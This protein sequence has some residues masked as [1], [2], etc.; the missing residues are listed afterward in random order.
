MSYDPTF[1]LCPSQ[2]STASTLLETHD[3]LLTKIMLG[4]SFMRGFEYDD[5]RPTMGSTCESLQ[6]PSAMVA[7]NSLFVV[8]SQRHSPHLPSQ[9]S[10]AS[11]LLIPDN[12]DDAVYAL[13]QGDSFVPNIEQGQEEM[14]FPNTNPSSQFQHPSVD[15]QT[16]IH[17]ENFGN[18]LNTSTQESSPNS[19]V[20]FTEGR[21][22]VGFGDGLPPHNY[23]S[24]ARPVGRHLAHE[25]QPYPAIH[26]HLAMLPNFNDSQGQSHPG[27]TSSRAYDA[28]DV[29]HVAPARGA[30]YLCPPVGDSTN[31]YSRQMPMPIPIPRL[32]IH[33]PREL[34]PRA[35]Y[36]PSVPAPRYS[37]PFQAP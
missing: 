1:Q 21:L 12:W 33:S 28:D 23:A 2:V 37:P 8:G 22:T 14:W 7:L 16:F 17:P 36:T 4:E 34:Y 6:N 5:G 18:F 9:G 31:L 24:S 35:S 25:H 11:D 15:P 10:Q 29:N 27:Y 32:P 3:E 19:I 30:S 13:P 26:Q 20:E